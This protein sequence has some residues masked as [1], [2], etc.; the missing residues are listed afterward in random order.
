MKGLEKEPREIRKLRDRLEKLRS[1]IYYIDVQTLGDHVVSMILDFLHKV[2]PKSREG[3]ALALSRVTDIIKAYFPFSF[4]ALFVSDIIS[5]A[6]RLAEREEPREV[7]DKLQHT[8]RVLLARSSRSLNELSVNLSRYL[9][10]GSEILVFGYTDV[11]ARIILAASGKVERVHTISYWPLMSGRGFASKLHKAGLASMSWPDSAASQAVSRSDY[12]II[13]VLG[14]SADNVFVSEAGAY[15]LSLLAEDDSKEL[16]LIG[17]T[18][19]FRPSTPRGINSIE[20]EA[21]HP[22][23]KKMTLRVRVFDIVPLHK[24][25]VL[26]T[27]A[28]EVTRL[29]PEEVKGVYASLLKEFTSTLAQG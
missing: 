18:W 12:V 9:D 19:N 21:R 13:P 3:L 23:H 5:V 22:I 17:R 4:S 16:V 20:V 2:Q 14:V 15:M 6:A 27:E 24:A 8:L 1:S 26:I 29:E 11:L 10:V 28:G 7:K 25:N